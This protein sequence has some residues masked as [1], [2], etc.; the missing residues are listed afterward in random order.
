MTT[1]KLKLTLLFALVKMMTV[2]SQDID[3]TIFYIFTVDGDTSSIAK[4]Y[5]QL[6]TIEHIQTSQ[7]YI[8]SNRGEY[9]HK[10]NQKIEIDISINK[11]R[12]FVTYYPNLNQY[13][14]TAYFYRKDTTTRKIEKYKK[15]KDKAS[16]ELYKLIEYSDLDTTKRYKKEL[17][18]FY[19]NNERIRFQEFEYEYIYN[20]K[21]EL[22]ERTKFRIYDTE[23]IKIEKLYQEYY[24]SGK[25]SSVKKITFNESTSK[26]SYRDE[27]EYV[28]RNGEEIRIREQYQANLFP[29][30]TTIRKKYYTDNNDVSKMIFYKNSVSNSNK[31]KEHNYFY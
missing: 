9:I 19:K 31:W 2:N 18:E 25:I 26:V 30:R 3:S 20:D 15:T 5:W 10:N 24:E 16:F 29:F 12:S 4:S 23:K 17:V 22:I 28:Y 7:Y 6:D 13:D 8:S 11:N 1:Y 21:L 14:S 27:Y